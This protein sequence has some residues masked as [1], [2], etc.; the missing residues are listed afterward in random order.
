[1]QPECGH[2]LDSDCGGFEGYTDPNCPQHG[3]K[4]R[5]CYEFRPEGPDSSRGDSLTGRAT[6]LQAE[7]RG[8]TPRRSTKEM[9]TDRFVY[10]K[11]TKTPKRA[12]VNKAL[13]D[14][15]GGL[16]AVEHK[17]DRSY[18]IF[19]GKPSHPARRQKDFPKGLDGSLH[20]ERWIEVYYDKTYVDV[21]TRMQDEVTCSIADGFAEFCRRF[22]QGRMEE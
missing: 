15:I 2:C 18:V 17:P 1:M 11:K 13:E 8:S 21:I 7:D 10:W 3:T 20:E 19:T 12:D 16:G 6:A 5:R 9:A 4:A 14:Y 22:W